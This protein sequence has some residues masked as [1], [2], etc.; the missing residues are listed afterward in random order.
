MPDARIATA[1]TALIAHPGAELY[2]SDRVMLET[3]AALVERSWRVVVAVPE[4]GPLVQ[5]AQRLGAEVVVL[6]MPVVRKSMLRPQNLARF[7]VRA[8][9]AW[10]RAGRLLSRERPDVV[11][12]STLTVPLWIARSRSRGVPVVAHVHEG[13]RR[14][15][16]ILRLAL[17]LPL[18]MAD[19]VVVNSDFS[20]STLLEVLPTLAARSTVVYNG[21]AAPPEVLP[22][23]AELLGGMRVVYVGRLSPRK[24]VDVAVAAVARLVEAGIDARL[25]VVG[26]VF[27]GYEWYR[28][29]LEQ[30]VSDLALDGRVRFLGFRPSVWTS[31]AEA[32]V[33]VVPSRLEEPFGNTAVEAVLSARPVVVS[34]IGGLAEATDGFASA[35]S[36]PADDVAA[37]TDALLRIHASWPTF[38]RT[39][40]TFAPIAAHRYSTAAYRAAIT[41]EIDRATGLPRHRIGL[42][43]DAAGSRTP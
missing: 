22:G 41:A 25:D 16:R 11:Y 21:V 4:N 13:E 20:R 43:L 7:T 18:R 30:Q 3:I 34:S 35:L 8:A 12:V 2:G 40:A 19:R 27:T 31:F 32:D 6:A 23:R 10:Y 1:P 38:R 29:Q 36:V 37:L 14:A 9:R 39:A 17:A 26:S 5:E 33:A 42:G 24:G 15:P 28:E